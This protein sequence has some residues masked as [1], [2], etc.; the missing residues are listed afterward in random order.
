[1]NSIRE[2]VVTGLVQAMGS[3][4]AD[5]IKELGIVAA[6]ITAIAGL[7]WTVAKYG[8]MRPIKNYIDGATAQLKPNGGTHLADAINRTEER[9][10][11]L[12]DGQQKLL[13]IMMNHLKDHSSTR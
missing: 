4:Y 6:A 11:Q 2:I 13:D 3:E 10:D 9:V 7:L 12:V 1:M 8:I 5:L